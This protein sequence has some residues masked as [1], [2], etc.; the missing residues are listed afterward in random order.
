M[1]FGLAKGDNWSRRLCFC[2]RHGGRGGL[3]FIFHFKGWKGGKV[4]SLS[5]GR[6]HR[7]E[8]RCRFAIARNGGSGPCSGA[9][10]EC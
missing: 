3:W 8:G 5:R 10:D 7:H 9:N 2:L 4:S 6:R 1:G